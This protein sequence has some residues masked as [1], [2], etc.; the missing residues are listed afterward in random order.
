MVMFLQ[1]LTCIKTVACVCVDCYALNWAAL[2]H[3]VLAN[4]YVLV[5]YSLQALLCTQ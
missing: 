1:L 4:C 5:Y 2:T 3:F